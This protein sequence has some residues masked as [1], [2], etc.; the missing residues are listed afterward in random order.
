MGDQ[1]KEE[2]AKERATQTQFLA[3]HLTTTAELLAYVISFMTVHDRSA[4]AST[5]PTHKEGRPKLFY[6]PP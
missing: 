2:K 4:L 3:L 1:E 5:P 6:H